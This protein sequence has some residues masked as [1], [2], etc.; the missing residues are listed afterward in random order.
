RVA[1]VQP[2]FG[3]FSDSYS[4]QNV[5]NL[6]CNRI[7]LEWNA[8]PTN[9]VAYLATDAY[10]GWHLDVWK[11]TTCFGYPLDADFTVMAGSHYALME[12]PW[13]KVTTFDGTDRV[14]VGFR[15]IFSSRSGIPTV[16]YFGTA[17]GLWQNVE[18]ERASGSNVGPT[19]VFGLH[20]RTMARQL[21]HY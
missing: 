15:N 1:A 21:T 20:R 5:A 4:F 9:P 12:Q 19:R 16:R 14:Y 10:D 18:I 17:G 7:N 2:I 13:L 8:N 3:R 6:E 11:A